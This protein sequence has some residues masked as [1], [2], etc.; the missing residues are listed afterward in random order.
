MTVAL[1]TEATY[2]VKKNQLKNVAWFLGLS[3]WLAP[4]VANVKRVPPEP[5]DAR[6]ILVNKIASCN[7]VVGWHNSDPITQG[8]GF[9][10]L[11]VAVNA[12]RDTPCKPND[13]AN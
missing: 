9:N 11:S 7:L 2:K 13:F 12:K 1:T 10:E 6:V 5:I 8:W 4:I 3:N